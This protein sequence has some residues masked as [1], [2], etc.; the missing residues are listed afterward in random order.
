MPL[1]CW[2]ANGMRLGGLLGVSLAASGGLARAADTNAP[3]MS[4]ADYFEGGTSTYNDWIDFSGGGFM[5]H[6]NSAQAEAIQNWSKGGFGGIQDLHLEGHLPN[7][8]LTNTTVTLDGNSLY[9]QH[10]YNVKLRLEHPNLWFVQFEAN[11]FRSWSDN[12][13]GYYPP[14]GMPYSGSPRALALD[15]GDFSIL[16]GLTLN[17][18]PS[19]TFKYTHSYRRGNEDSTIWGPVTPT[20]SAASQNLTPSLYNIGETV[21]AFD[22]NAD[23]NIKGTDLKVGLHYEHG[24]LNDDLDSTF[25]PGSP[26]QE[27]VAEN[28]KNSYN[29]F[30]ANA[31]SETW[32]KQHVFVSAGG[33]VANTCNKFSGSQIFGSG[34][35]VPYLP[36]LFS[37]MGYYGMTGSSDMQEYVM[38]LNLLTIPVKNLDVIPSVRAEKEGWNA[39]SSGIGTD[40]TFSPT[41]FNGQSEEDE[42]DVCESLDVRYTGFTNWVWSAGGQWNENNGNLNQFGGLSQVNNGIYGPIG[43]P[44]V[45]NYVDYNSLLQKYSAGANWYPLPRLALDFGGYYANDT[46][47]Y[48]T[49]SGSTPDGDTYPGNF[50]IQGSKTFDGNCRVTLHLFQSV[51]L[52]SRY[53]YQIA[54]IDTTPTLYLYDG[55][56]VTPDKIETSRMHSQ[57]FGQNISW[58]PWSRLSLEAGFTY[59]LSET[60]TPAAGESAD[61]SILDAENNYWTLNFSS[62]L[63]LDNK[64]DLAL[65]YFYYQAGDYVNDSPGGVPLGAGSREDAVT[66]TLT[67]RINS[68][69]RVSLKYGYYNYADALYGGNSNFQ[70]N[71]IMASMQYRF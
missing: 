43:T 7:N 45:T 29:L 65:D 37:G 39:S 2:W 30:S 67:R 21:D 50:T 11:D 49:P 58:I 60:K 23:K 3:P 63:V 40:S 26:A 33:M 62:S 48:S 12:L 8:L 24:S 46:Y 57:I 66:A 61:A 44:P 10:D 14:T 28:Q 51:N 13:G 1:K 22:L 17:N 20:P 55:N 5:A 27:E 47:N 68:H 64:T 53:E 70:A 15:T 9:D 41:P 25:N 52:V 71:T 31:S 4:P 19:L 54:T 38:D 6:G 59:V 32:I 16:A 18:L 69:V 35:G 42:V 56:P 36:G 34:F